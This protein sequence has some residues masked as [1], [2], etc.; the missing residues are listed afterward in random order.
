MYSDLFLEKKDQGEF[1][2][3]TSIKDY[4]DLYYP[5]ILKSRVFYE[6]LDV[7]KYIDITYTKEVLKK[8]EREQKKASRKGKKR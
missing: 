1:L 4:F 3:S 5:D 7:L 2:T 6:Y 8:R